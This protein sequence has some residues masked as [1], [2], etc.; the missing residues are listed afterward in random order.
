MVPAMT[1]APM[2]LSTRQ[3]LAGEHG[4]VDSGAPVIDDGVYRNALARLNEQEIAGRNRVDRD[5]FFLAVAQQGSGLGGK[6]D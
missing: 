2:A 3:A 5:R 4:F 1:S 6:S